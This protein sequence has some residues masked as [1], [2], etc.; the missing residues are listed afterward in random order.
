M[1]CECGSVFCS[2]SGRHRDEPELSREAAEKRSL[3]LPTIGVFVFVFVAAWRSATRVNRGF[4]SGGVKRLFSLDR[5]F[6]PKVPL[7]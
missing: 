1:P 4:V 6:L 5:Y 7:V 3:P 2:R